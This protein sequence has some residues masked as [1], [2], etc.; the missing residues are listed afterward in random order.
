MASSP[1]AAA[2]F[3]AATGLSLS[4]SVVLVVRLERVGARLG[5]SEALLGLLAALAAD[6]PEITS[7][8]TAL[9]HGQHDVG[10]GVVLGSNVFNLAALL[11]LGAVVAGQVR[12]HPRV[13]I[14]EG[15][16]ALWMAALS[17][18]AALGLI[19]P[20]AALVLAVAVLAPYVYVSALQPA[21]RATIPLSARL[22]SWLAEAIAEEEQELSEAIHPE[23]GGLRDAGTG[24]LALG[25]VLAASYAMERS[26]SVLGA[27]F[28]V[29][30]AI[31]G[32]IVLAAVTSLPNAVA[33]VYL[34]R[35]GRAAAT[36]SE[37]L[38]SNTLNVLAGLL[39][40]AALI[41][42]PGLGSALPFAL[43]YG[44]LT[45]ATLALALA[46]RGIT[47]RSGFLI[48]AGYAAFVITVVATAH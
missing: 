2:V 31:T 36:L 11:G 24:A 14:F 3:V 35:R 18:T 45:V 43:W 7:A 47:R 9:T 39:L 21:S 5:L 27:R 32:A 48:I 38:N 17:I 26:V 30:A 8:V 41:A 1:L 4:A 46:G 33:A 40:P 13:V 12:L 10:T 22:R 6:T 23:K 15:S 37:A 19:A 20:V 16:L 28:A 25:V 42:G 44:A 34:A 29:P